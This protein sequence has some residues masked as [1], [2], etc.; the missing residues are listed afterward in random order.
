VQ[1]RQRRAGLAQRRRARDVDPLEHPPPDAADESD[2]PAVDGPDDSRRGHARPRGG[3]D[4]RRLPLDLLG[5]T[6]S[7]IE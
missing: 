6:V 2:D 5:C 3:F 1:A 7:M 4:E